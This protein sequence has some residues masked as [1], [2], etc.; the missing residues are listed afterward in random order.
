MNLSLP[1]RLALAPG[2]ISGD[3]LTFRLSKGTQ[4]LLL[5]TP[6]HILGNGFTLRLGA[7]RNYGGQ[8]LAGY[9]PG[10]DV[11]LLE[12]DADAQCPQFPNRLQAVLCISGEPGD[13]F[14]KDFINLSL[15][16]VLQH[17]LEVSPFLCGCT[18]DTLIRVDVYQFPPIMGFNEIVVVGILGGKAVQL[19]VR[20][21]TDTA[22]GSNPQDDFLLRL[23]CRYVNLFSCQVIPCRCHHFTP[24]LATNITT[25]F[26]E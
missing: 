26:A 23:R 9:H 12:E 20:I 17:P 25:P 24:L 18:G 14:H 7:C 21:G 13:G 11:M 4:H 16:A 2:H 19:I 6:L 22:V 3:G 5:D 1:D 15:A 8:H 10:I